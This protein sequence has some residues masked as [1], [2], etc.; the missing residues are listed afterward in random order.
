MT[1]QGSPCKVLLGNGFPSPS[2]QARVFTPLPLTRVPNTEAGRAS[3]RLQASPSAVPEKTLAASDYGWRGPGAA[4]RGPQRPQRPAGKHRGPGRGW[5]APGLG[6]DRVLPG[7]GS[8]RGLPA[9]PL[10]R[11]GRG[12]P[13]SRVGGRPTLPAELTD[14]PPN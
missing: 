14:S 7:T 10:Q 6:G 11:P 13:A 3:L 5:S 2:L 9:F 12:E 1:A 8:P 4:I